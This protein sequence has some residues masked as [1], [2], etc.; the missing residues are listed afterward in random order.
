MYREHRFF[1]H[2]PR[3]SRGAKSLVPVLFFGVTTL[4]VMCMDTSASEG[5]PAGPEKYSY[6]RG[7]GHGDEIFRFLSSSKNM[8]FET[9]ISKF[10]GHGKSLLVFL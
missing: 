8:I 10:G 3:R 9:T 4:R 7:F 6:T 2:R 1:T 5:P